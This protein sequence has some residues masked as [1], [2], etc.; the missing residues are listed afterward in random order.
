MVP[1]GDYRAFLRVW[2]E[3]VVVFG[4]GGGLRFGYH[5]LAGVGLVKIVVHEVVQYDDETFLLE[6]VSWCWCSVHGWT[7]PDP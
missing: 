6:S 1:F 2:D 4:F 7:R 5:V 3:E